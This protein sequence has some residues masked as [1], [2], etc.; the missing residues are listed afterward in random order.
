M[1]RSTFLSVGCLVVL[2]GLGA[3]A[4]FTGLRA[5]EARP[6]DVT[7]NGTDGDVEPEEPWKLRRKIGQMIL[8]GFL[9]DTRDHPGFKKVREQLQSGEITGVLYLGRNIRN[10]QSVSR[11]NS[12]LSDVPTGFAKPLLAIDQEGGKVQ[13]LRARHG[14]PQTRSARRMARSVAPARASALYATLA[15]NLSGWGFNLNLGPVVDLNANPRNPVIGRLDRAYSGD[16][17]VVTRYAAAFVDGHRSNGVL[18]ALKHFPGHGSSRNDSHTGFVDVSRTWSK[19]ELEPF[20]R[21]ISGDCAELVMSAHV[22]NSALQDPKETVPVSLSVS[23]LS[24]VLRKELGYDGV[25]IS[26]DLQMDA[27]RKTYGL[28]ETV[29]GAVKAGTDILLFANDK[30]PDPDIPVKVADILEE[31]AESDPDLIAKIDAAS[32]RVLALKGR[33]AEPVEESRC[34]DGAE[35]E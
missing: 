34:L 15:R 29:V 7:G 21:L 2:L 6:S 25:I 35:A 11:M 9:G 19:G 24:Q 23:A 3:T 18:T 14:F 10:R 33:L 4:A 1:R 13:R 30:H 26:D 17:Q 5:Q 8:V 20:R 28:K 31:A 22:H 32:E 12:G 16:P 27:I